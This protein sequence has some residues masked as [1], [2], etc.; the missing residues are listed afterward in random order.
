MAVILK[1]Q[2]GRFV[3]QGHHIIILLGLS[4][5]FW[6]RGC[7]TNSYFVRID[8]RERWLAATIYS[9]ITW[10]LTTYTWRNAQLIP[11]Q[12]ERG[13]GEQV[14]AASRSTPNGQKL[15]LARTHTNSSVSLAVAPAT[16]L[17]SVS[18]AALIL[19]AGSTS[20]SARCPS[21]LY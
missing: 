4:Q 5:I 3:Y 11:W 14:T 17:F 10:L 20:W 1:Q 9:Y 19:A 18:R 7:R 15:S 2:E 6:R 12:R 21:N 8:K 16:S 13:G